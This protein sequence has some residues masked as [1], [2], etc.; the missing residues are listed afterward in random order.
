MRAFIKELEDRVL[1]DGEV[2]VEEAAR[3]LEEV[4]R[5]HL[6]DLMAA[7]DR[8]R[9][10]FVGDEVHL[11][12]IINAKSGLCTEDC[13]FCSQAARHSTEVDEY[14]LVDEETVLAAAE[15]ARKNGAEA[16]G[17]VAAWRGLQPGPDLDRVT[18]LIRTASAEGTIH[19]DA[20]LGLIDSLEVAQSLKEA[21]LHTYNHNLETAKSRFG[22]VCATHSWEDRVKTAQLVREAGLHLCSGGIV[23]MGETAR[24]RAELAVEIRD[25]D[26]DMVPLNFLNPIEGTPAGDVHEPMSP[27]DAI[28]TIAV[29]RLVL[30]RHHIMLAGGREVVL[31]QLEPLA[32][33]AGASANMMGDYLTTEGSSPERDLGLIQEMG[34]KARSDEANGPSPSPRPRRQRAAAGLGEA[35]EE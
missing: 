32:Y 31:G 18:D 30:P 27:L 33:L 15:Q 17:L 24:E 34:L 6:V 29:F 21:G 10:H 5:E 35:L 12:S 3:L 4:G 19:V 26:P 14:S 22:E 9:R 20:S 23:G 2:T 13:G 8:V 1:S 28:K 7:A 25:L 16:L 11:C